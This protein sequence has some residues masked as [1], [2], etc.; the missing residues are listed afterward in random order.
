[1]KQK[2]CKLTVLAL[3]IHSVLVYA[4]DNSDTEINI[5]SQ[6]TYDS[7]FKDKSGTF[8]AGDTVNINFIEDQNISGNA[9]FLKLS[10]KV[11]QNKEDRNLSFI[12]VLNEQG[13]QNSINC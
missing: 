13:G 9:G 3:S 10:T 6:T 12:G 1:M 7:K 2:F 4:G 11:N 5:D 8:F